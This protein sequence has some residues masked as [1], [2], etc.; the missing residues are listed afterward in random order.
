MDQNVRFWQSQKMAAA[1][2]GAGKQVEFLKYKGLDHQ[3]DDSTAR[4]DLL[5]HIGELLE[6]TIGQ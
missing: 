6:R 5:T 2:Q 3:L 1:L 4:T